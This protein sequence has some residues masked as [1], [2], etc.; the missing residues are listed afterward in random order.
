VSEAQAMAGKVVHVLG[1]GNSA[2]QAAVHLAKFAASVTV[3]VRSASLADSMSDYLVTVLGATENIQVRY[4]VEV[5][6][7][8]GSDA[9]DHILVRDRATGAEERVDSD[10]VFVLIG[11]RP[12]TEWLAGSL[13]RDRWG[14][15]VTGADLPPGSFPRERPPF[16][17]ETSV[18]GVFAVG[19]VRRDSVKRVASAVGEGAVAIPFVHRYLTE[20]REASQAVAGRTTRYQTPSTAL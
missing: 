11:S 9:L 3:M 10:G 15:I 18:P 4:D 16:P 8:G 14:S 13:E 6:G 7:G 12:E 19:D 2:G 1:G 20:E 17:S 5:V